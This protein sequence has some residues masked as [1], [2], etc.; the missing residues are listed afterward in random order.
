MLEAFANVQSSLLCM[1][2]LQS[3][4]NYAW[5][6][7]SPSLQCQLEPRK[8]KQ[9]QCARSQ[10][11]G[12][13]GTTV[14]PLWARNSCLEKAEWAGACDELF[15]YCSGVILQPVC[16]LPAGNFTSFRTTVCDF[17]KP[18]YSYFVPGKNQILQQFV[19]SQDG[20]F[21]PQSICPQ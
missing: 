16:K 4:W 9:V 11:Y 3:F 15:A 19:L 17:T 8:R 10:E 18:Y 7:K 20:S 12:G 5:F 2:N 14:T 21:Y 13:C 6:V 1:Y